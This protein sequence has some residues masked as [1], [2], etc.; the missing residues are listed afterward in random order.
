MR[1]ITKLSGYPRSNDKTRLEQS[2]TKQRKSLAEKHRLKYILIV[3]PIIC[4][5]LTQTVM[6]IVKGTSDEKTQNLADSQ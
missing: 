6:L 1:D 3:S 4:S 5:N 2:M